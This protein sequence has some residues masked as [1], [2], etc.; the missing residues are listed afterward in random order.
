MKVWVITDIKGN[1]INVY[2]KKENCVMRFERYF[3]ADEEELLKRDAGTELSLF[4]YNRKTQAAHL[5]WKAKEVE[6]L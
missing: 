5:V 6:V 2:E 4:L 3:T 1:V